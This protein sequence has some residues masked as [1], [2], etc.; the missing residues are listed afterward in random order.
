MEHELKKPDWLI[1]EERM[2]EGLPIDS[3]YTPLFYRRALS[4]EK[5]FVEE[6]KNH[7]HSKDEKEFLNRLADYY[8]R[9]AGPY[10]PQGYHPI[11]LGGE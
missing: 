3:N 10:S 9:L 6:V 7:E 11:G 8:A 1:V 2:K 5:E 4:S